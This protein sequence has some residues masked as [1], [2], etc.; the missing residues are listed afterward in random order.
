M[1]TAPGPETEQG[2][3]RVEGITR[4][5]REAI[6]LLESWHGSR[7][8]DSVRTQNMRKGDYARACGTLEELVGRARQAGHAMRLTIGEEPV[9]DKQI[10]KGPCDFLSVDSGEEIAPGESIVLKSV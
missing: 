5:L 3:P 4:D 1:K 9:E 8:S 10:S 7:N 6:V 2:D